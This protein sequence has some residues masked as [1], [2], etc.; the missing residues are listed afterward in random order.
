MCFAVNSDNI[1]LPLLSRCMLLAG[2]CTSQNVF[3]WFLAFWHMLLSGTFVHIVLQETGDKATKNCMKHI[4]HIVQYCGM[5]A[6]V[7]Y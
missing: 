5:H 1:Y 4:Y 3:S 7:Y 6:R 2:F